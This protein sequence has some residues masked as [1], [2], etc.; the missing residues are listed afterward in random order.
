MLSN[1][2]RTLHAF[3]KRGCESGHGIPLLL[4]NTGS[5]HNA[6]GS[7]DYEPNTS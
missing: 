2:L 4:T 3:M 5:S 1:A 6:I 7:T